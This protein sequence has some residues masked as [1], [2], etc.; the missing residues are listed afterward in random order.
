MAKYTIGTW[1]NSSGDK[2][3][4]NMIRLK[5]MLDNKINKGTKRSQP[6]SCASP[7]EKRPCITPGTAEIKI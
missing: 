7:E 4:A 1:W 6:L 5:Y 3:P 2:T